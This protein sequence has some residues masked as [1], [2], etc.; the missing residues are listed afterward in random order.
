MPNKK[1]AYGFKNLDKTE[2]LLQSQSQSVVTK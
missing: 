2:G 1:A